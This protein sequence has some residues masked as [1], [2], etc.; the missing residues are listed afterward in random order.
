MLCPVALP[1]RRVGTV[2]RP[3]CITISD[4][5]VS[6][7]RPSSSNPRTHSPG[8]STRTHSV[9]SRSHARR[10]AH[11]LTFGPASRPN[12]PFDCQKTLRFPKDSALLR[13]VAH[14]ISLPSAVRTASLRHSTLS[15][16]L[17]STLSGTH[18]STG[19]GAS[20]AQRHGPAGTT[21]DRGDIMA[22]AGEQK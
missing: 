19:A 22:R 17:S 4:G 15:G 9:Q 18:S 12:S 13:T 2:S 5:I 20:T 10:R 21:G 1:N 8:S 6:R 14:V 16:T 3:L 7:P 11:W